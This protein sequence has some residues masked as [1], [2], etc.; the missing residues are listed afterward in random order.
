[1]LI[2]RK[3]ARTAN[4]VDTSE[5]PMK[6]THIAGES[7]IR[8]GI[9]DTATRIQYTIAATVMITVVA[10]TGSIPARIFSPATRYAA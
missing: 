2:A 7:G 6:A 9:P 8:G 3:S 1:M 4:T 10:A 5:I